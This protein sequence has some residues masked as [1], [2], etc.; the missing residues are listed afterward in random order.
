MLPSFRE[1]YLTIKLE[2]A[3]ATSHPEM[4]RIMTVMGSELRSI[5]GVENVGAHVGRAEF[6]D[7]AVNV[8]SGE[9]WVTI[10]PDADYDA[11]VAAV[12]SVANG[13]AGMVREVRTY[14]QQILSQ[15]QNTDPIDDITVR[16][17]G[18]DMNVLRAE[19]EK[20]EH[21]LANINGITNIRPIL[22]VEEPTI[23]IKVDLTTAQSHGIK[24]GDVRRGAAILLSGLLVGNLF[25]EQK[26]FDVVVWGTPERRDDITDISELMIPKPDGSL[27]RL[28]DVA[29]VSIVPAPTVIHHEGMSAYLDLGITVEDR[30]VAAVAGEVDAAVHRLTYPLEYHVEV[31]TD[32][33]QRQAAQQRLLI[34]SVIALVGSYLLLQASVKSWVM[35]FV[36]LLLLLAA[37]A[38]GLLAAILANGTLSIASLFGLLAVLGIAARNAIALINHYQHLEMERGETFGSDMVLRGSRDRVTPTVMTALTTSLVLLPFVLLGNAPGLEIVHPMAIIVVGG[39][40]VSTLL[41]LVA[42]PALYLRYGASREVDLGLQPAADLPAVA[43]D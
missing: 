23:E 37:L 13:Y 38:G 5:K 15:P 1:P 34:A 39:L 20:V 11:T 19:A 17:Y 21:A 6:G 16:V 8:N 27:V 25:E 31:L 7:Q 28:G 2:G 12:Q 33:E 24:P 42:L 14:T 18:E 36:T 29:D 9:L 41:N 40:I 43:A 3:P 4:T 32:H 30:S 35:A 10:N 22:P 26:I